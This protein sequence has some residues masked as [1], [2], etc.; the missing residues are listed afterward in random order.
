MPHTEYEREEMSQTKEF[1]FTLSRAHKI[2][3]RLQRH[4]TVLGGQVGELSRPVTLFSADQNAEVDARLTKIVG[5]REKIELVNS[6]RTTVRIKIAEK[7][8]QIGQH[9]LLTEQKDV[10]AHMARVSRLR[11]DIISSNSYGKPVEQLATQLDRL[12]QSKSTDGVSTRVIADS[13]IADLDAQIT[14]L[15]AKLDKLNDQVADNN[16]SNKISVEI[17]QDLA[18]EL[19]L[20]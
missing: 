16:A 12:A 18:A 15:T 9:A 6:L 3:E 19:G 10:I 11:M 8:A 7:N 20:V 1:S 17:P 4:V 13:F 14:Q 5:I 2:A